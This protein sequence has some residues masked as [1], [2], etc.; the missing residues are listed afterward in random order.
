MRW[1]PGGRSDD[2]ED[3]RDEG[4]GGGG[5]FRIGGGLGLGGVLILLALSLI[6]HQNFFAL[7]GGDGDGATGPGGGAASAPPRP[8]SP[9]EERTVQFV[10]F[11]LD[12]VQQTWT[13][14][15]T[16]AGR[17]YERAKLVLFTRETRSGC[18]VA[19]SA[20][21]P[22]Y[23]PTDRKVYID[24]S[25]YDELRSRI[26]A[27]GDFAQAYVLAH[28]VGHH[29]QQLLGVGDQVRAAQRAR[30][31]KA[32]ALSVRLELQ[33]DCLA[34]IWA[35]ST[36]E[37][38]LLEAGDVDEALGAASAVGDDRIQKQ[39]GRR[40]NPETW[41]HGSARQRSG[42]FRRGLESGRLQDCDTFRIALPGVEDRGPSRTR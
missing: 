22:F 20:S 18:G 17:E 6:F 24:L 12:D 21:G 9:A 27:P 41:T 36:N 38:R 25:F 11:V 28:E 26:G 29:V 32:D 7:L 14:E 5:G 30:P 39:E 16:E 42:W 1:T 33:A 15:F 10:S 37:R 8:S 35:H 23:C 40:V 34:G 2:V 31:D 19:E 13:R 4:G 3:R